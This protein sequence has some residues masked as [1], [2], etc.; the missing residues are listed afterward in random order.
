MPGDYKLNQVVVPTVAA[1]LGIV[2]MLEQTN[3]A[4]SMGYV[5]DLTNAFFSFCIHMGPMTILIYNIASGLC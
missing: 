4:S 5:L 1:V 3:K 2:L